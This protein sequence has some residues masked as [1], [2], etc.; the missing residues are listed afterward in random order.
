MNKLRKLVNLIA[1]D[2][3]AQARENKNEYFPDADILQ[4]LDLVEFGRSEFLREKKLMAVHHLLKKS[5]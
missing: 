5:S 2:A 3:H 1:A 4:E